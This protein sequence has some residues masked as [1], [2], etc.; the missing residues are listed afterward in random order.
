ME[1]NVQEIKEDSK[2]GMNVRR[3]RG[4]ERCKEEERN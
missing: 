1:K 2:E 4:K 3:E